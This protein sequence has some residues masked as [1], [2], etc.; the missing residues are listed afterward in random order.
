EED[1]VEHLYT[2]QTHDY[3]MIFTARGHCYWLKV[4]EIPEASRASRGKPIVN[5]LAL[6]PDERIASIV[7]VREFRDDRFLMFASRKGVVKKTALSAYRHVRVRGINAINITADDELIDVQITGGNDEVILAT[8]EGMA[9]RFHESDVREMGRVATGVRGIRL[10]NNDAV[11]GMVVIREET[12]LNATLL[13]VTEKGRGKRTAIDDYRFQSRGG[14]GV[15]NF[16]INEQTGKIVAIKSV[17]PED[18]LMLMSRHGIVTRQRVS[19]IRV[20]GRATQGVRVMALDQGDI[21]MDVARV[22]P[23]DDN[24]NGTIAAEL[25]VSLD[26]DAAAPAGLIDEERFGDDVEERFGDDVADSLDD[27]ADDG[28]T[29]RDGDAGDMTSDE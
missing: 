19:E 24:G 27:D 28:L 16:R 7:P 5:L 29:D 18:E 23:E 8:Y 12:R 22:I 4:H 10:R 17:Q 21:L 9:I 15:I 14:M 20:I 11:V 2:A 3:L 1:W 6:D 25:P 26:D 13:I